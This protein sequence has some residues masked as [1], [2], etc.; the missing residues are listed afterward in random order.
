VAVRVEV[1]RLYVD[2]RGFI[3][4]L[5][6]VE[7]ESR[8]GTWYGVYLWVRGGEVVASNCTC[9]GH[10]FRRRCKHVERVRIVASQAAAR[11]G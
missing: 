9:P 6:R 4:V 11:A 8:P 10:T 2:E 1:E 5:A 3:R 7:S